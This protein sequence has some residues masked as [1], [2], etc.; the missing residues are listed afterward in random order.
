VVKEMRVVKG[1]GENHH[2]NE[3]LRTML[4]LFLT[5]PKGV[6]VSYF[7]AGAGDV[8]GTACEIVEAKTGNDSVAKLYL[9]KLNNLPLMMS[10]QGMQMP[11]V[12]KFNKDDSNVLSSDKKD[13]KVFVRKAEAPEMAEINVKFSDYR[14]VDGLQLPHRWIQSANGEP[15]ETVNIESY[16]IN[17]ANIADK[18]KGEKIML[19]TKKAQ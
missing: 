7:Y 2:N 19:R 18:F 4:S 17:P 16:E 8:D 10:Y 9:S 3:F 5:A 6:D 14:S 13:V 15:V 11:K 12:I 1:N